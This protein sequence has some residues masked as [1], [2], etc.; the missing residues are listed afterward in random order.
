MVV[1]K[2]VDIYTRKINYY[3]T[4][5]MGIV[6]H[7]NYIRYMEEARIHMMDVENIG[8]VFV[9]SRGLVIPVLSVESK[10]IK[11]AH[12][13]E[14]IEIHTK[15]TKFNGMK[16]AFEYEMYNPETKELL[17]T[18]SSSHAIVKADLTPIS[19]KRK[20]PDFYEK[21]VELYERDKDE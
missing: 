10:F 18:G 20:H 19:L 11:P 21:L 1:T 2:K 5:Q 15:F 12:F 7:S 8:L 3:D 17:N 13:G 16:F 9:E 4:D 6:H 14:D